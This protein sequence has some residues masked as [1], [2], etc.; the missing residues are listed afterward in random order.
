MTTTSSG[1]A[2]FGR[3]AV[4]RSAALPVPT[5]LSRVMRLSAGCAG[6][7]L[8]AACSAGGGA[9]GPST[10][11]YEAHATPQSYEPPGPPDDPWGPYIR[12]ASQR[13]NVPTS[14]IRNVMR[15]ESGGHEYMGG[16]LTVS[17]AGAMG[18]M[19]LEPETYREMAAQ[20]GLGP[21]PFNPYDNIMAGTA[22]IHEMYSIFGSPGFLAAYNAGPGRLQEYV[23]DH[24]PLP[25]ETQAYLAMIAPHIAGDYPG[26]NSADEEMAM[27]TSPATG[28]GISSSALP[29]APVP[30]AS[31][32]P[33]PVPSLVPPAPVAASAPSPVPPP[34]VPS[35]EQVAAL[36]AGGSATALY[37]PSPGAPRARIPAPP[38]PPRYFAPVAPAMAGTRPVY[39]PHA[40][41]AS[42]AVPVGPGGWAIQVGAYNNPG[43]AKAALG[44]AELS[45]DQMLGKGRPFVMSVLV[46]GHTYYRA[47][48]G[49]L[50]HET[51][52]SA[53]GRLSSGPTGCEVI[54]PDE[55]G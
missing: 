12:T 15:V 49:G 37:A 41:V 10:H 32:S 7:A 45:A 46:H 29:S 27:N 48:F 35:P 40:V 31:V 54:S 22:Y 18:L 3:K 51:A 23:N 34:S 47:R 26:G 52:E 39:R 14:W 19:Q 28:V 25:Q 20:Y 43:D 11:Y 53:C 21:D 13:F 30:V 24:V 36:V 5:D 38:A 2:A 6:L 16:H 50:A 33:A 1:L 17:A 44:I 8:L 55:R 42:E 9:S 4:H